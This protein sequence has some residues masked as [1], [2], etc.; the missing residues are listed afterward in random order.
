ML[1]IF[2]GG[3]SATFCWTLQCIIGSAS[4]HVEKPRYQVWMM[5]PRWCLVPRSFSFSRL[6]T[7]ILDGD[8]IEQVRRGDGG[9]REY[10][11]G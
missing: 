3:V 4:S 11:A 9:Q 6:Q 2:G 5:Q 8:A 7:Y 1:R 10:D